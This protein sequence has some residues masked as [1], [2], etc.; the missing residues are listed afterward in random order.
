[1][2]RHAWDHS[3]QQFL[4][5][6]IEGGWCASRWVR[7]QARNRR[8]VAHTRGP[9]FGHTRSCLGRHSGPKLGECIRS[10]HCGEGFRA[11]TSGTN[12]AHALGAH[13]ARLGRARF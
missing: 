11:H 4:T 2:R 12:S 8:F 3:V 1:M 7:T 5:I 6:D 10:T 13:I 9:Q